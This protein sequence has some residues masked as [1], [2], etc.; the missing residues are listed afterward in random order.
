MKNVWS[1]D[2]FALQPGFDTVDKNEPKFRY[3]TTVFAIKHLFTD[4][5]KLQ[6]KKLTLFIA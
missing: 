6:G 2:I 5:C 1:K 3:N 4:V